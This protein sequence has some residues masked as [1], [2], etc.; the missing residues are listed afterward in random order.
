MKEEREI[1]A[2]HRSDLLSED[3][4]LRG[5]YQHT[6]LKQFGISFRFPFIQYVNKTGDITYPK[7]QLD[8]IKKA[9][10]PLHEY[11]RL[12]LLLEK[13]L[14]E[15]KKY[16]KQFQKQIKQKSTKR[17]GEY[18]ERTQKAVA[19]I[20][21]FILEYGLQ[22][23]LHPE[24]YIPSSRTE[25]TK[26]NEVLARIAKRYRE[27]KKVEK[28][29]KDFCK[30]YGYLGMKYYKGHP[31]T[32]EE[33]HKMLLDST[34]FQDRKMRK[35]TSSQAKIGAALLRLRT[36]KWEINCYGAS[37]FREYIL[38]HYKNKIRYDD[39]L[40][41][42]LEEVIEAVKKNRVRKLHK[43]PFILEIRKKGVIMLPDKERK[44][45]KYLVSIIKGLCAEPGIVRGKV[46]VVLN[47][48]ESGKVKAGEI[49][50]AAMST[51]DF[52]PAMRKAA[53]FVTDIGGI[54]CH[55]AIVAREMKKPCIIG[56]KIATK[57]LK[58]GDFVEI[59]ATNGTVKKI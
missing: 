3:V 48:E 49:L 21:Y 30:K 52:L 7:W 15:Y 47:T 18:F 50:V 43:E 5:I 24:D 51:P 10:I 22:R 55:A 23:Y 57:V 37:L 58:D 54:T 8:E 42:R 38:K 33:V 41:M 6:N 2:N 16:L 53:A 12:V 17:I 56:T 31:W 14:Q 29:L 45:T 20:P 32:M 34:E 59:D 13:E 27:N 28:E 40:S 25:I 19:N 35:A 1:I 26:A 36:E 39:L 44:E 4:I 11:K 9:N 46:K